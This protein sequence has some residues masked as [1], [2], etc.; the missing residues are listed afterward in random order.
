MNCSRTSLLLAAAIST[1]AVAAGI[2]VECPA[3]FPAA[4]IRFD[5]STAAPGWT[6]YAPSSLHV[7]SGD[8]MYGPPSSYLLAKPTTF[9]RLKDREVATWNLQDQAAT[10]KWLSCGYGATGELTLSQQLP[11]NLKECTVTANKDSD[12]NISKVMARCT[13]L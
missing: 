2:S 11:S 7:S 4:A 12:G 1:P 5:V 3:E 10:P 6:P 9:R 8:V 13:G